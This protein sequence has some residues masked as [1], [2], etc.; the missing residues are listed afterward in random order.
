MN[1]TQ[2]LSRNRAIV[3]TALAITSRTTEEWL[4]HMVIARQSASDAGVTICE[5][6]PEVQRL[7]EIYTSEE[8]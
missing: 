3:H 4:R 2:Q 8:N 7:V 5:D 1:A 6:D